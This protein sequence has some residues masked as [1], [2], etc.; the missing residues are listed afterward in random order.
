MECHVHD[1]MHSK[2]RV[3]GMPHIKITEIGWNKASDCCKVLSISSSIVY[4]KR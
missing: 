4:Q 3:C 1:N 2:I